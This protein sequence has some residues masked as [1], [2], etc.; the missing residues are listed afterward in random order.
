MRRINTLLVIAALVSL[1]ACQKEVSIDNESGLKTVSFTAFLEAPAN[2]VGSN[3]APTRTYLDDKT[4]RWSANDIISIYDGSSSQTITNTGGDNDFT[5]S[6]EVAAGAKTFTAFYPYNGDLYHASSE[7]VQWY[8]N[9]NQT[10]VQD[11]FANNLAPMVAYTTSSSLSFK[12]L[13]ALVSFSVVSDDI[14]MVVFEGRNGEKI[15]GRFK[16]N[17]QTCEIGYTD[18]YDGRNDAQHYVN[19]A[20]PSDRSFFKSGETY[21]IVVMPQTLSNGFKITLQG[22]GGKNIVKYG[23]NPVTLKRNT[24]LKLGP[25]YESIL[26][27]NESTLYASAAGETVEFTLTGTDGLEWTASGTAGLTISPSSGTADGSAHAISV[28]VPAN[29]DTEHGKQYTVTISASGANSK[30]VTI[31]QPAKGAAPSWPA[32]ASFNYGGV[33]SGCTITGATEDEFTVNVPATGY[34]PFH[35]YFSLTNVTLSIDPSDLPSGVGVDASLTNGTGWTSGA[36]CPFWTAENASKTPV[37]YD[38]PL[39]MTANNGAV[40]TYM[41]HIVRAGNIQFSVASTTINVDAS[42]T[43]ATISLTANVDWN[44]SVTSGSASLSHSSGSSNQSIVVS[45]DENL[46]T[47]DPVTYVVTITSAG[48]SNIVVTINQSESGG[49]V[50]VVYTY[51]LQKNNGNASGATF[52]INANPGADFTLKNIKADGVDI[53][54]SDDAVIEAVIAKAFKVTDP[55]GEIAAGYESR[56]F[57]ESRIIP[58]KVYSNAID[59]LAVGIKGVTTD[60][61]AKFNWY[62]DDGSLAGYYYVFY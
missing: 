28:T 25:L 60:S 42:A 16:A 9:P 7:M 17:A 12:N 6:A 58:S 21:Y 46:S 29:E 18:L 10:A 36:G 31:N 49:V 55:T 45:F 56:T 32:G 44:A 34:N 5:F 1:A 26:D 13:A 22:E 39:T 61:K 51:T 48:L 11:G 50:Q 35:M 19:F 43:S 27:V 23:T 33:T 52:G 2:L 59:G 41:M 3:A 20:K 47:V 37:Q 57:G 38:V 14:A 62:N 30:T 15:S 8:L 54:Y 40:K 24:I 4:V 53:D